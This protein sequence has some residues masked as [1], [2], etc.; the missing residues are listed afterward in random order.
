MEGPGELWRRLLFLFRRRQFDRDLEEEMRF[1]LEMSGRRQFGSL[2][3]AQED[4]REAW[5]WTRAAAWATDLKYAVRALRASP[6]FAAAAVLTMALGLGASTAVFSV[7]HAVLLRPLPFRNPDRLM[8]IWETREQRGKDRSVVSYQNFRDWKEQSQTFEHMATFVGDSVRMNVGG[9][10]GWVLGS[11]VSSGFFQ[12]L[13]AQPILGRTFVPE[14]HRAAGPRVAVLSYGFWQRLGGGRDLVGKTVQ[15]D[16]DSF[17]VVGIMPRGFAFP[18][19]SEFWSPFADDDNRNTPG[20]HW[21]RVIGRLKPGVTVAQAQREMQTIAARLKL[22]HP[23]HNAGIGTNVV[24]L[25]DQIVGEARRAL[26]ILMGAVG[27]LLLI[28]CANVAGL[29]LVRATGRR[30]E[31]A[32]RIALGAGRWR[33]ARVLLLES[34]LLAVAG[35]AA[36]TAAAYGLVRAFVALDPIHLPRIQE[37]AVNGTV[38]LYG[39]LAAAATGLLFGLAP[40]L[41]ASRPDLGNRLKEGPGAPGSGEFGKNRGRS[42]LAAVQIALAVM[43]VV[44]AGLLLHSFVLRVSVP[45][46]FQPEGVLAV[47]LP[48]GVRARIDELLGRLRALPGV[49]EAGAATA[50]PQDSAGTTCEECLEIEGQPKGEGKARDTGYMVATSGF[51]RAAGMTLRQGRFFTDADGTNAPKVAVINEA[52]S[53]RD[54]RDQNPIGRHVRWGK[55]WSTVIGVAGNVKGFGVAGDPMP[56][57]YFSNRQGDWGNPVQV[58][59]RTA[60]PPRSLAGAVRKEIRSWNKRMI[61]GKVESLDDMLAESVAVPRFYMLLVAGFAALALA[62]S[63]VGV[64]GTMNYAV[65][66]RTHEIGI[67]MA[68]GAERGDIL[69]MVGRQGVAVTA[70]G[71]ALGLA[72]A[73]VSTR[74]LEKLL[75]GIRPDDA[76][77]F[78]CGSGVLVG[79][80]LLACYIP[81]RRAAT[82]D[83]L[84]ALRHE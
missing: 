42:V 49:Q 8:M 76:V 30:R 11:S 57:V 33:V 24:P 9:E 64:Y 53:K 69:A 5:G 3:L 61:F 17:I 15:L 10:P 40:A 50:F 44:G 26:V 38:L 25:T 78:A 43:L 7:V 36:G 68:L 75:F 73:W 67:R 47:E 23:Q 27:C 39:L 45:L 81:A 58:L 20:T 22:A 18:L 79:A 29:L 21:L 2:A 84:E 4:S 77:A 37:V 51:F 55:E 32:L 56:A 46:G 60:V 83:P 6:G 59:V 41:R 63:G 48:W 16:R 1:H 74:T 80:V 12:A 70:A 13:G 72:G 66:R 82:V 19:E 31:F 35:G 65:V 54:F 62:V 71:M 34:V 14:E 52:L 28:A